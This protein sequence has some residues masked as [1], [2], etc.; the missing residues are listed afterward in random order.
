MPGRRTVDSAM[1]I[2]VLKKGAMSARSISVASLCNQLPL[3]AFTCNMKLPS[4]SKPLDP[5][6][7]S[8]IEHEFKVLDED[9]EGPSHG[10]NKFVRLQA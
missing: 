9:S 3:L 2:A 10:H 7:Y 4:L 5:A 6:S 8:V 1:Y